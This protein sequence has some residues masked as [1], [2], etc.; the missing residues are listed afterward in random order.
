M[1]G[2]Y[3]LVSTH[4]RPHRITSKYAGAVPSPVPPRCP[5]TSHSLNLLRCQMGLFFYDI[6]WVF[7]TDVMVSVATKFDAPIKVLEKICGPTACL[8]RKHA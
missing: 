2:A 6:F 8:K 4:I 3:L 1:T 5:L 7:G